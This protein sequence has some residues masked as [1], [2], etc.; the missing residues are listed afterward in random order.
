MVTVTALDATHDPA[1]RSWVPSANAA[2]ADFPIQNLPFGIFARDPSERGRVGVAIGDFVL[3]IAAVHAAG[4]LTGDAEVAARHC[5]SSRLNDLMALDR[6]YS[7]ALRAQIS[8]MLRTGSPAE[9][10]PGLADRVLIR[11]TDVMMRVPAEIGD[12]TDF[13][14][15]VFHASNVGA[16][17]RPDNP[18]LPNYK[19]VPIG[20]HGRSSTIIS[21]GT[22]VI[23]PVGQTKGADDPVPSVGPTR[24]LDYEAEAGFFIGV[25]NTL[26][27]P[28]R[29]D[30][31]E[32]H[33]FGVCLVN[34]WSARD[35]QTW[36][37][38][39]LGPFLAKNFATTVS[40]WVVTMD[41]LAPFRVPPFARPE[42]D[43]RPLPYLTAADRSS[44][45]GIDLAI[46]VWLSS[47]KM[48]E[49]G[50]APVRLSRS[51]TRDLYWTAAQLL[52]HHA[53][54]GCSLRAG[55]LLASGTVSGPTNDALGCMLELTRRG[56]TPIRLPTG[57]SRGFLADG[58]EVTMRGSCER[59]GAVRIG[60][61][62]CRGLVLPAAADD[63]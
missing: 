3:D 50:I 45:S 46:E 5:G 10:T 20:Y 59:S 38:Q 61:G 13:Y 55:D 18:L 56:A 16:L 8:A 43:P 58:D 41:A 26:G 52:T 60:L 28:V 4:Q 17:F 62:E 15:S 6:R 1:L 37:Y 12:Y 49:E 31:A 36:E 35:I 11:A 29:I 9:R 63:R 27:S 48:R 32:S 44:N 30:D 25:A 21:S 24:A 34:D 14:A 2:G 47:R 51:N 22:P 42:G 53:S 39:P 19:W 23:R 7:S 54:N 57:E 40:P 33:L